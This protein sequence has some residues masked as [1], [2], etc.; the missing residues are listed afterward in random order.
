[1]TGASAAI[2]I[3]QLRKVFRQTTTGQSVV[4]ID[5]LTL[6]IDPGELIAIVGQTG[7]GKSTLFDLLI[8]LEHPTSGSIT[9]GG[10]TPYDDFNDFRGKIA[11]IFQQ[12]R[13]FPWRSSLDNVKLPLELI[14]IS[15]DVQQS[16][17]MDWLQRLGLEKFANAYP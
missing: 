5:R 6:H 10:K 1:M 14:G 4:A 9:I 12:D 13:L 8:G 16:R 17:A 3:A 2:E 11:T 7:C 15:E